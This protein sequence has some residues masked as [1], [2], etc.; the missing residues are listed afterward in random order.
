MGRT[1]IEPRDIFRATA[2]QFAVGGKSQRLRMGMTDGST[3]VREAELPVDEATE[4]LFA[5]MAG[6]FWSRMR[7]TWCA[8]ATLSPARGPGIPPPPARRRRIALDEEGGGWRPPADGTIDCGAGYAENS[9]ATE[10][11]Q[12]AASLLFLLGWQTTRRLLP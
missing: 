5:Q 10:R 12:W 11:V 3:P 1:P 7:A 4:I 2:K 9:A 6:E 8:L